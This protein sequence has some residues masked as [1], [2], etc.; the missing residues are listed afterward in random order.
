[1]PDITPFLKELIT[2]PG[3]SGYE[4]P[5]AAL[6]EDRWR[7]LVSEL[8][9]S[10]LGSIHGFLRGTGTS[11]RPSIMVAAHMDAIGLMVNG[12]AEGGFLRISQVGSVD[13]R[14]LPGQPVTVHGREAILGVIAQPPAKLL[15][16]EIGANPVPL[17][18]LF[19]DIGLPEKKVAGLVRVGDLISF[20]TEPTEMDGDLLAGHSLDN[21]VSVAAL[22]LCLEELQSR[23]HVWDVW[24][25]ATI[26]EEVGLIGAYTSAFQLRPDLALVIDVTWAKAPG[27]SDWNTYPLGKGPTLVM[28]ANIH[29]AV[30]KNLK[31]LAE[32]LEI[33]HAIEYAPR[34]SGTDAFATQV[35]AEGIP[36]GVICIPLRYMHTPVE[37]VALKDIQRAGRLI[38]EFITSLT[39]DFMDKVTWE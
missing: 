31:E 18:Y 15:P 10:R 36:S 29:P 39:V 4:G 22:T 6:I 12:I 19:V 34:H 27:A 30:F 17:E 20:A 37:M 25:V 21:R 32:K 7:P 3:L 9:H 16:P 1:M 2:A 24:A 38:T 8:S 28:G 11:P 26:R 33:P 14:V 13:P 23:P 35:T 5:V